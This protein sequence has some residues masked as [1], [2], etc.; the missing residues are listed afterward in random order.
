[1]LNQQVLFKAKAEKFLAASFGRDYRPCAICN[2]MK[3]KLSNRIRELRKAQRLSQ[4]ELA[5][6]I[7][8]DVTGA[9][10]SRLESGRMELTLRWMQRISQALGV[11][12]SDLIKP[13]AIPVKLVPVLGTI[14]AGPL[15]E[16][17]ENPDGWLP[18]PASIGGPRVFALRPHGDSMSRIATDEDL[19]VFDPDD[20]DLLPGRIYAVR[21]GT[22]Q[23]TFKRYRADPPRLEP[24]SNNPEHGPI[25]IGREPFVIIGRAIFAAKQL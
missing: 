17:I 10:I 15:A 19:V 7:G 23:A 5:F 16:A 8:E 11:G 25:I 4:E 20:L 18:L 3:E 21:N 14:P 12:E 9:A 2:L 13:S 6:R 22:G 24:D 1:M